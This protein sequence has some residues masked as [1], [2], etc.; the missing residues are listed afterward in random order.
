MGMKNFFKK[1]G[2]EVS[3]HSNRSERTFF[4]QLI[5]SEELHEEIF[6]R[7]T[8]NKFWP[9]HD[10]GPFFE[11]EYTN[12]NYY[13]AV[14]QFIL[15]TVVVVIRGI[16]HA[17][18]KDRLTWSDLHFFFYL[19]IPTWIIY[20]LFDI[21]R[22]WDYRQL[23]IRKMQNT[24]EFK[25][26]DT[27]THEGD[28]SDIYIRIEALDGAD[29]K[30]FYRLI[31]NGYNIE[32]YILTTMTDK[33]DDLDKIGRLIARRINLNYFD[34]NDISSKNVVRH[35]ENVKKMKKV[36][37]NRPTKSARKSVFQGLMV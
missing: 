26:G 12:P 21:I 32:K 36:F 2:S 23:A 29:G 1:R 15:W 34:C 19:L 30:L 6:Q 11:L 31:L 28:L 22:Y 13:K 25:I 7:L 8:T 9:F 10:Y 16:S 35:I 5:R 20:K 24:Y 17:V 37:A 18:N 33:K 27:V 14:V 4:K 3:N